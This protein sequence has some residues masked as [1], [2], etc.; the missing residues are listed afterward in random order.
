MGGG[1]FKGSIAAELDQKKG[2][3]RMEVVEIDTFCGTNDKH[4]CVVRILL[5]AYVHLRLK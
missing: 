4:G 2:E 5:N 3:M 1:V